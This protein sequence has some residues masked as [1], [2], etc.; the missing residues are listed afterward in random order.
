MLIE[1]DGQGNSQIVHYGGDGSDTSNYR[2]GH[3]HLFNN[4]LV[5]TRSGNTTLLRLSTQDESAEVRNNVL[6]VTAE[7]QRLAML[8]AA[9]ALLLRNN[10]S[11]PGWRSS[12]G[13]LTGTIDDD[14]STVTGTAPGFL[15]EADQ[16]YRP[17]SDSPLRDAAGP[18]V[19]PGHPLVLHYVK[20]LGSEDRPEDGL[21]DI[22]AYEYC[23][24]TCAVLFA[25]DF[26]S[27][28]HEAWTQKFP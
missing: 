8:N 4:T 20:H 18:L 14:G 5:S 28:T 2:K 17:R 7:G 21:L 15:D 16:N 27:G 12:H 23:P 19:A 10:W 1:G 22:G 3:L 25:D 24:G 6:Y 9:G 13:T 26:E 11:K